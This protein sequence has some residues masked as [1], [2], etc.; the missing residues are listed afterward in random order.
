VRHGA[1]KFIPGCELRKIRSTVYPLLIDP[2]QYAGRIYKSSGTAKMQD[3]DA[4]GGTDV[5]AEI[6]KELAE[7]RQQSS[8]ELFTSVRLDTQCR[9]SFPV[10]LA[11]CLSCRRWRLLPPSMSIPLTRLQ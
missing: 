5:D 6:E 11:Y 4:T 7:M 2:T 8:E 9:Q 10:V 3:A 1:Q